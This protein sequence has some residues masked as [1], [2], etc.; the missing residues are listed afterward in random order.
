MA[1]LEKW[2][3]DYLEFESLS[4]KYSPHSFRAKVVDLKRLKKYFLTRDAKMEKSKDWTAFCH[5]GLRSLKPASK[6]RALSTYRCFLHFLIHEKG[7][8][9]F[10]SHEF[11]HVR[12]TQTLPRVM[13]YD[14]V[15]AILKSESKA[16]S[17]VEMLY[18]TGGRVSE[19]CSL[20]WKDID[21][22]RNEIRVLGKGRRM[23]VIPL[24]R[25]LKAKLQVVAAQGR[26]VFP[27][28]RDPQKA[29]DPRQARR[30]IR[31][32]SLEVAMGRRVHPHLFRH[33]LATHLLDEGADLRFIQELLGHKT[34][35]T[36]QKYLR[37]SKQRLM[38]VFDKFHP[39]A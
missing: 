3:H 16:L 5:E 1:T 11:P 21:F 13:S 4:K 15:H 37:V 20:E 19:I 8:K 31:E 39:R 9:G 27:S 29:L 34:L 17:F 32:M 28:P 26:Y 23:R 22:S 6:S 35:S 30:W 24:A 33:S 25:E 12:R 7:L 10:Q 38:E 36:T 14:E 18:A 2:I